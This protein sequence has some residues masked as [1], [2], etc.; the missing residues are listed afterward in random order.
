MKR[1]VAFGAVGLLL[2][3]CQKKDEASA[4]PAGLFGLSGRYIGVGHY[5]A[6]RMWKQLVRHQQPPDPAGAVLDDDEEI[7]AVLDSKTGEIR[8][9]GAFSGYC[10]RMNPWA[11]PASQTPLAPVALVKHAKQ[12][13]EEAEAEAEAEARKADARVNVRVKAR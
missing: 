8:Q 4:A 1:L 5:T 11:T 10:I 7:I 13:D 6:G 12:L 9:C 3:G 2:C